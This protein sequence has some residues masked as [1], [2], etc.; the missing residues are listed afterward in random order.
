MPAILEPQK[1]VAEKLRRKPFEHSLLRSLGEMMKS[2]RVFV[3]AFL[4]ALTIG[5]VA[6]TAAADTGGAG[7]L[8]SSSI[9][10]ADDSGWGCV[11]R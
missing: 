2:A 4:C 3:V 6:G 1:G 5:G 11:P 9:A 8:A 10:P 7:T